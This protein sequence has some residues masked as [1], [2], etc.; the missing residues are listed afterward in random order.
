VKLLRSIQLL[1]TNDA[2]GAEKLFDNTFARVEDTAAV[3]AEENDGALKVAAAAVD[4]ALP[5]GGVTTAGFLFI[6]FDQ[7][8]TLKLNG[9][10]QVIQLKKGPGGRGVFHLEG[11]ATQVLLS[12]PGAAD[13]LVLYAV[14]GV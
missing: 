4:I 1:V 12:N 8:L 2:A 14:A 6:L 9:G 7:D 10:S 11:A 3:V 13:A 5:F